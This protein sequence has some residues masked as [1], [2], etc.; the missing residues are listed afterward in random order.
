MVSYASTNALSMLGG[1]DYTTLQE[2][3]DDISGN[4]AAL[5]VHK[6]GNLTESIDG[7]KT[8]TSDFALNVPTSITADVGAVNKIT[9]GSTQTNISNQLIVQDSNQSE[10]YISS[11]EKVFIDG[12]IT[13]ITN[14]TITTNGTN[15]NTNGLL[16]QTGEIIAYAD[17]ITFNEL[18]SGLPRYQQPDGTTTITAYSTGTPASIYLLVSDITAVGPGTITHDGNSAFY[19]DFVSYSDNTSFQTTIGVTKL[20]LLPTTTE[21]KND[22]ITNVATSAFKVQGSPGTD[23][24]TTAANTT[25]TLNPT[26]TYIQKVAG[27]DKVNA[28]T[29]LTTNTNPTITNVATTAFKVQGSAGTDIIT[30]AAN[31]TLTLNPTATYIQKVAGTD[32]VNATTT[33]LA[34]TSPATTIAGLTTTITGT[35]SVSQ[36]GFINLTA[37]DPGFLGGT[38]GQITLNAQTFLNLRAGTSDYIRVA[39]LEILTY[40]NSA[41]KINMGIALTTNTNATINNVASAAFKVQNTLGTDKLNIAP[42][43]TKNTNATITEVATTAFQVQNVDGTNRLIISPTSYSLNSAAACAIFISAGTFLNVSTGTLCTIAAGDTMSI[44]AGTTS[45][46]TAITSSEFKV[47]TVQ[48]LMMTPTLTTITNPTITNVATTAFRVEGS[49]GVPIITTAANTTL[50]LNPTTTYTQQINGVAKQTTTSTTS[51]I[52]NTSIVHNGYNYIGDTGRPMINFSLIAGQETA[53]LAASQML[54]QYLPFGDQTAN[55]VNQTRVPANCRLVSWCVAGDNTGHSA[56]TMTLKLSGSAGGLGTDYYT[57]SGT[58]AL[59]ALQN[60][61]AIAYYNGTGSTFTGVASLTP[62]LI[63]SGTKVYAYVTTTANMLCEFNLTM[64]FQQLPGV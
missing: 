24:I 11:V 12:T 57:Q 17:N 62:T 25:L 50:T 44:S 35:G 49:A 30:T 10:L 33:T 22:T 14:D 26:A 7:A 64:Y 51:T 34:I 55:A 23:I 5:F 3:I 16:T 58:L 31:T 13:T 29:M 18:T 36:P 47:N 1:D 9:I 52:T 38:S 42:T 59:N 15:I 37:T 46:I 40:V 19:G 28:T 32:K 43:L 48:T 27:T 53:N 45:L 41:E 54:F 60:D 61:S 21:I 56:L 6:I 63:P 20:S 2:E 4:S 39:P 8:F